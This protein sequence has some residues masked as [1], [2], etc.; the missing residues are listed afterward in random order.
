MELSPDHQMRKPKKEIIAYSRRVQTLHN[1]DEP[2]ASLTDSK[3]SWNATPT[4]AEG[5]VLVGCE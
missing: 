2:F 1:L 5:N 4:N 3:D